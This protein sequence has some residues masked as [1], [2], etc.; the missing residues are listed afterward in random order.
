MLPAFKTF[1]PTLLETEVSI[2]KGSLPL[3]KNRKYR[4]KK[5]GTTNTMIKNF[6]V[7]PKKIWP[8]I[9]TTNSSKTESKILIKSDKRTPNILP[10]V[11]I[12]LV[13]E[14]STKLGLLFFAVNPIQ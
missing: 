6:L 8:T 7:K 10:S 11:S 1:L 12:H 4:N 3:A 2:K 5:R 13:T 9:N 14:M